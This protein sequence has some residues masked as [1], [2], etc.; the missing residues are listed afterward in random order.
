MRGIN[1]IKI[2]MKK[3]L[4][5]IAGVGLTF[6]FACKKGLTTEA[7]SSTVSLNNSRS[8]VDGTMVFK[9]G[10]TCKFE[11]EGFANNISFWAGTMGNAYQNRN[12]STAAGDPILS[13]TS[14]A[15]WGAQSNTLTVLA[16]NKLPG[17]DSASVVNANWTNITSRLALATSATAVNSGDVNLKDLVSGVNDSLFIAFKYDG[18]TGSTQRTWTIT[19]YSVVNKGD[20]FSFQLASNAI[21]ASLGN[22]FRYGN[23]WTPASARWTVSATSM[24][25]VGGPATQASNTSWLVSKPIYVGRATS[26]IPTASVKNVTGSATSSYNYKYTQIGEYK[27]TFVMFN[28][29]PNDYQEVVKEFNIRI[30]Q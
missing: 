11:F 4:I 8:V 15:Q 18:L 29:T 30:V 23:V 25:I 27:A 6:T 26:D 14:A 28:A 21:D 13:F 10:D 20:G 12:R 2:D 17:R 9:L 1:A 16:T 7:P 3:L 19:N 5:I 24:V 22:W